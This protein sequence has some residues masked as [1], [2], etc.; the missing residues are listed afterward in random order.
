MNRPKIPHLFGG[1]I[2]TASCLFLAW[3]VM[4]VWQKLPELNVSTTFI[5]AVAVISFGYTALL[6]LLAIAWG[7]LMRA[8]SPDSHLTLEQY[9]RIFM[10]MQAPKYLPGNIFHY[11]GRVELLVRKRVPSHTVVLSLLHEGLLLVAVALL[12]GAVGLWQAAL[13]LG[14]FTTRFTVVATICLGALPL[15]WMFYKRRSSKWREARGLGR[16]WL[17]AGTLYAL[18]FLSI[19]GILWWLAQLAGHTLPVGLCLAAATV[20]WLLGFVT[21]GAPGGLGVREAAMLILLKPVMSPADGLLLVMALRL[22]TL[23]GDLFALP[24]S[25]MSFRCRGRAQQ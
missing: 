22:V 10:R 14:E 11:L 16:S 7:C 8:L 19:A 12:L 23:F 9:W 13:A 5:R 1:L 6:S 25:Y 18:F 20:P 2:L 24:L 17:M 21:P 4:A 15:L 3:Q